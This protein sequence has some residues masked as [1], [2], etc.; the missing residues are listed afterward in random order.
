GKRKMSA[1]HDPPSDKQEEL[2]MLPISRTSPLLFFPLRKLPDIFSFSSQ[3]FHVFEKHE[4]PN[5]SY[6]IVDHMDS[7]LPSVTPICHLH[8]K[9]SAPDQCI[10][11]NCYKAPLFWN[12]LHIPYRIT[13]KRYQ[14]KGSSNGYSFDECDSSP[15]SKRILLL[16]KSVNSK[17]SDPRT[18]SPAGKRETRR[19]KDVRDKFRKRFLVKSIHVIIIVEIR[20][21]PDKMSDLEDF[22]HVF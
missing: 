15:T 14:A 22:D 8:L 20:K 19:S 11:K 16:S 9:V 3:L 6:E 2:I 13:L 1:V 4:F 17:A 21:L 18:H 5:K 12:T 7:S 10:I